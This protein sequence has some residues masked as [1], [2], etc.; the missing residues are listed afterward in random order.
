MVYLF[1][2]IHIKIN[3]NECFDMKNNGIINVYIK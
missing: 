3:R 1:D 2:E